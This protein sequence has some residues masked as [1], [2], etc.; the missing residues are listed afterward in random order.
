MHICRWNT[1]RAE[2][3]TT[4]GRRKGGQM[5][6]GGG[7]A[8]QEAKLASPGFDRG[9]SVEACQTPTHQNGMEM[10]IEGRAE[11]H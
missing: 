10:G 11:C 4:P 5:G 2:H 1:E 8:T 9:G 7:E 3:I 6:Q